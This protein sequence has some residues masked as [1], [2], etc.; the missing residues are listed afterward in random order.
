M[1]TATAKDVR[2]GDPKRDAILKVGRLTIDLLARQ[3]CVDDQILELT[4]KEFDLLAYLAARPGHVF[5]RDQLLKSVWKSSPEWQQAA[6]VTEHISRLRAKIEIDPGRPRILR[7]VR[8][9]GYRLDAP[10]EG[11]EASDRGPGF[12][13]CTLIHVDGRIVQADQAVCA[14]LGVAHEADL[15]GQRICD[16]ASPAS[17]RAACELAIIAESSPQRRTQLID[18]DCPDGSKVSVEVASEFI[19]WKGQ[20]AGLISFNYVADL[21]ARL[22]QLATGVLSEVSDAVIIT[23]LHFHIRSWNAAAERLYGW[24]QREVLGRH[25]VDI[26]QWDGDDGTLAKIFENLEAAGRWKGERWHVTR[27]GSKVCVRACSTLVRGASNQPLFIVSVSRPT[28]TSTADADDSTN[29][30]DG[31]RIRIALANDEF[32]VYYQPIVNLNDRRPT[33]MEALVRWNHPEFGLL[34]ADK[35]IDE[36]ERNGSIVE[37]GN[38]VLEKACRQGAKWRQDGVDINVSVNLSAHQIQHPDFFDRFT[39]ILAATGLDPGN[40]WL[41]LTETALVEEVERASEVLYRLADLGVG[42][43]IDDFGTGWASLTYLRNFPIHALK[44]DRSFISGVGSNASDTAI[45]RSIL[46]LGAELGLFVVAEGIET[47]EQQA[48]LQKLGCTIGQGYLYGRPTPASTTPIQDAR[49][50]QPEIS[51]DGRTSQLTHPSGRGRVPIQPVL[52]PSPH[53]T[54][55]PATSPATSTAMALQ[56][57]ETDTVAGLLR[58]LLRIGSAHD[59]TAL[60]HHTIHQMG[61]LLVP[62][63]SA[64]ANTLPTDV[65]LGEGPRLQVD[66]DRTSM[67]GKQLKRLVPTMT[68]DTQTAIDQLPETE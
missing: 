51:V 8:G 59:A 15:I 33:T 10:V 55:G 19:D 40:L 68:E 35:F 11:A 5:N 4:M 20:Q 32:E 64:G 14:L 47:T 38:A 36:A 2:V 23:D 53:A 29:S 34:G 62:A 3:A 16:L 44:I 9:A 26:L 54:T 12:E 18:L 61:G 58:G 42:L 30:F 60:L 41:E 52:N 24:T 37:L 45:V 65:S 6:T 67:A 46:S 56:R 43:A 50:M 63:S 1:S 21:S 22:R 25:I 39:T 27:D 57:I 28:S 66:V 31:A 13:P 49:K 17:G 7:T 48:A